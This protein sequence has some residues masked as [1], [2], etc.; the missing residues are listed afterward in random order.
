MLVQFSTGKQTFGNTGNN[1]EFLAATFS[2]ASKVGKAELSYCMILGHNWSIYNCNTKVYTTIEDKNWRKMGTCVRKLVL[3]NVNNCKIGAAATLCGCRAN[4]KVNAT[5][6]RTKLEQNVCMCEESQ[7]GAKVSFVEG[8]TC[9]RSK[10]NCSMCSKFYCSD[11][12]TQ[13]VHFENEHRQD[14]CWMSMMKYWG[15]VSMLDYANFVRNR[16]IKGALGGKCAR[17]C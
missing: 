9:V 10:A 13:Y 1:M 6:A 7:T 15:R 14:Y 3:E 5:S 12:G 2:T 4:V 11:C 8:I 17:N 16:P